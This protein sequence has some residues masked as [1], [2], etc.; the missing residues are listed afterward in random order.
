MCL[1]TF[2]FRCIYVYTYHFVVFLCIRGCSYTVQSK[3][4]SNN[5]RHLEQHI[6]RSFFLL[7]LEPTTL[8]YIPR[9]SALPTELYIYQGSSAGRA[10]SLQH[11][12]TQDKGK[13]HPTTLCMVTQKPIT[14]RS[15]PKPPKDAARYTTIVIR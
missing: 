1:D 7:G 10:L 5:Q 12:T 8:C 9:Q 2:S 11:N 6:F 13:P 14:C 4:I 15:R 3:C